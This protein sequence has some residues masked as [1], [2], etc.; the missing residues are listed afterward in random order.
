VV[1]TDLYVALANVANVASVAIGPTNDMVVRLVMVRH[2][3]GASGIVL[4]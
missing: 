3:D 2:I 1:V 4:V